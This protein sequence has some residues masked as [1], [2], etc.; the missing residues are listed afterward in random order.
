[1]QRISIPYGGVQ[2]VG[3]AGALIRVLNAPVMD[4]SLLTDS[5]GSAGVGALALAT[6]L[7]G[8]DRVPTVGS[9]DAVSMPY[10]DHIL[11]IPSTVTTVYLAFPTATYLG[12]GTTDAAQVYVEWPSCDSV[13]P[14]LRDVRL[15]LTNIT[16]LGGGMVHGV[17]RMGG[18]WQ[19][20]AAT[21]VYDQGTAVNGFN[22][23]TQLRPHLAPSLFDVVHVAAT[24]VATRFDL[25]GANPLL[26]FAGS[27]PWRWAVVKRIWLSVSA[28]T[29]VVIGTQGL[30][31]GSP[32]A[33]EVWR[34]LVPAGQAL[35]I[36]FDEGLSIYHGTPGNWRC[37]TA[38]SVVLDATILGG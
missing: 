28:A 20:Q 10:T 18:F 6:V 38:A 5:S 27:P 35:P 29:L 25:V 9:F 3:V 24:G 19:P 7:I 32:G 21:P 12:N 13:A 1:V 11:E 30:T 4:P 14:G 23:F 34:G 2:R 8:F 15:P 16:K 36:E 37:Y 33:E 26:T 17:D 22:T 31:V